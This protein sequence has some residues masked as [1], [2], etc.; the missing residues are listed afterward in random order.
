MN[1]IKGG[2]RARLMTTTLLA[3]LA[4]VA[5]PMAVATIA[6]VAPTAANAQDFTSGTITGQVKNASGA[7]V[8]N[9]T[10]T[11]TSD[12]GITR[13]TTSDA[14]G[15]YVIPRVPIGPYK[16]V[17]TAPGFDKVES[18][19]VVTIG[20]ASAYE[21]TLVEAGS[22]SEVVITGVRRSSVDFDQTSTGLTVNV[23]ETFER[24]P[25]ARDLTSVTLLAP[26]TSLGDSAFGNLASIG[27]SSV[28]EN[29]YYI[30]GMNIT[31]FRN[32][33]GGNTV[34]FEFYE[35]VDVKTGGFAAEFGRTTGGAV[36]AVTRSGSNEFHGGVNAYWSP[37]GL[38]E[39]A[40]DT[41]W[42]QNS[43]D[44]RER[45]EANFW[46]SGPVIKDRLF[47]FGF[48]NLRDFTATDT[49][50]DGVVTR[51]TQD[52]PFYGGKI[53]WNI[54]DGHRL[55]L[56]Y[57]SDDQT[58][59]DGQSGAG[60]GTTANYVGG[61]T[62]IAKYTGQITDWL[63]VSALYGEN[64]FNQT[65]AGNKDTENSI[66]TPSGSTVRG[67]P[68]LLIE[69]GGDERKLF[70]VDADIYFNLLGRHHVRGGFDEEKLDSTYTSQYSGGV[71]YRY[72]NANTGAFA[73]AGVP[74]VR[75]RYLTSGGAYKTKQSAFY[76]QDS[77][78]LTDR[79]NLQLGLR[80]ETFDNMNAAGETFVKSDD[81]LAPRIGVTYDLLGD[82]T[83]K[84]SAFF[85]RYYLPI[86]A[87]TNIRMAGNENFTQQ[88]FRYTAVGGQPTLDACLAQS[89]NACAPTLGTALAP[90]EILSPGTIP[91][92][93]SL[94]SQNLKPQYQDEYIVGMERRLDSGW[95]IGASLT[96]RSLRKVMED[97]D[98][99]YIIDNYCKYAGISTANCGSI[100]GAGYVLLNPGSDLI[101]TPDSTTFP[102]LAGKTITIPKEIID[103]PKAKREY[104][105]LEFKFDRPF[106]GQWGLGGSYVLSES[107]GNYEGGVKSDNGQDDTGLTQDFD[108]P[109][110]TDNAYGLL[111]NHHA[112][113][114]KLYGSYAL[115]EQFM[116]GA[117]AVIQSPRKFGCIGYYPYDDGRAS[118]ATAS[119]FYC[120]GQ[121]T[122][123]GSQ[124]KSDWTKKVDISAVYTLP[125]KIGVE[126]TVKA[127]VDVF[128]IFNSKSV[129][130]I[131]EFGDDY[132]DQKYF[133]TGY[134]TPRFVRFGLS[135]QF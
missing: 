125:F 19:V 90:I 11:V 53:D 2:A 4:A 106:D 110:W 77:W 123:R 27:G 35:Q 122:P 100:N 46:L 23:Q 132:P 25:T 99:G 103:L 36:I 75:V 24:I 17:A 91:E 63:T 37:E 70:R 3:G 78:D 65:V 6:T 130:D 20:G 115:S 128:N 98:T 15:R 81:A 127:R 14:E 119:A 131:Q 71:Y 43:K 104:V 52:D 57:F 42:Q 82:R 118:A 67:N 5:A 135:A 10:I 114:L 21:L 40:P 33:L 96:Y 112:H 86:A 83:T 84:V 129:T 134:Q 41:Y 101:I 73:S 7:V 117:N 47:F 58:Q 34:P 124:A 59:L 116:L 92:A 26:Q 94:V 121:P 45:K 60:S 68:A 102:F 85:G 56:T 105:A 49:D 80:A 93:Q 8:P 111:P 12:R 76:I 108:E 74:Y 31:N 44:K 62:K 29:V 88:F 48:Y 113:T 109:G 18:Q 95:T 55:E 79:V 66:V 61:E 50:S 72:Y 89:S 97:F 22:V 30:N 120:D 107:K 28:G 51:N 64:S 126:G 9:A 13:S 32:F 133:P 38:Y 54:F 87:N 39:Q 1:S 69:S 16:L